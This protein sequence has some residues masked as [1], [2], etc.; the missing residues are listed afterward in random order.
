MN[1]GSWITFST[2]IPKSLTSTTS[3][4]A[5][6]AEFRGRLWHR[7]AADATTAPKSFR[8]TVSSSDAALASAIRSSSSTGTYSVWWG[9][10]KS[11]WVTSCRWEWSLGTMT[12]TVTLIGTMGSE[13][14][15]CSCRCASCVAPDSVR[16]NPWGEWLSKPCSALHWCSC[17]LWPWCGQWWTWVK[18][19][20]TIPGWV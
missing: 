9:R 11:F 13:T 3:G 14:W 15:A 17:C 12:S 16:S 10:Y 19:G 18:A 2:R 5:P 1:W 4:T 20:G 6:H 8:T 7:I